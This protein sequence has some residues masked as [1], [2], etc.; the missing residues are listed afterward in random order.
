ML[1][2]IDILKK[3]KKTGNDLI[4]IVLFGFFTIMLIQYLGHLKPIGYED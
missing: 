1:E 2:I 3:R 4:K